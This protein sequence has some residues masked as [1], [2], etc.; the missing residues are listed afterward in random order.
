MFPPFDKGGQGGFAGR[1]FCF[2]DDDLRFTH[3]VNLKKAFQT[4][5]SGEGRNPVRKISVEETKNLLDSGFRR[6]DESKEK[7]VQLPFLG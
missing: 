3:W 1:L 2:F 6:N 4:R 5:H 7:E